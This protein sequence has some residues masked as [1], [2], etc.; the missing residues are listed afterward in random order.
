MI[1]AIRR[2]HRGFTLIELLV[3]I[4]I[5]ALL[6]AI[7][8]PS[9]RSARDEARRVVCSTHLRGIGQGIWNYWT[10]ENGRLPY[11]ESP[12]TNGG[13]TTAEGPAHGYGNPGSQAVDTDP[14]DMKLW[15]LS[16]PNVLM[17]THLNVDP[18]IFVCPSA[19]AGWPKDGPPWKY[20]YRSAAANQPNGVV[21]AEG[22]YFRE[23]FGF[24]DG[25]MLKTFTV[26][27]TDDPIKNAQQ[28]AMK[29]ST[30]LRDFV[31][32][33]PQFRGPHKGGMNVLNRR[34]DVEYRNRQK[35]IED[36]AS[37]GE[38]VAF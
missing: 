9:L 20:T 13:G 29:R 38:G 19:I 7:L 33:D 15:P 35:V 32:R 10:S 22:S 31:R 8:V 5:I 36:L 21:T 25:R 28:L 34:L 3:V 1:S 12:M 23:N 6:M 11:L 14:F 17:P 4:S 27:M 18:S 24:M 37:F 16:L 2:N 30:Y 26:Q